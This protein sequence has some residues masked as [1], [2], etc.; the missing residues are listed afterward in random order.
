MNWEFE[1]YPSVRRGRSL[2][3]EA[4]LTEFS[5]RNVLYGL[6]RIAE[7][8]G[9]DDSQ[10]TSQQV[11][12]FLGKTLPRQAHY[13]PLPRVDYPAQSLPF[14]RDWLSLFEPHGLG[15]KMWEAVGIDATEALKVLRLSPTVSPA[16]WTND[17]PFLA[18]LLFN[19]K[20]PVHDLAHKLAVSR[21]IYDWLE[22][23][24]WW[25]TSTASPVR[26]APEPVLKELIAMLGRLSSVAQIYWSFGLTPP[27]YE[28]SLV[29]TWA[30]Y[31]GHWQGTPGASV[32]SGSA[33]PIVY[34][35]HQFL[36]GLR[37]SRCQLDFA[38]ANRHVAE[39][40]EQVPE[41]MEHFLAPWPSDA[42]LVV[43]Q[44]LS[45]LCSSL[46][47]KPSP[48]HLAWAALR[49][50]DELLRRALVGVD[51]D[52]LLADLER[53]IFG[54]LPDAPLALDGVQLGAAA[55]E[56]GPLYQLNGANWRTQN[57]T[58]ITLDSQGLVVNIR[59]EVLTC[60]GVPMM[61]MQTHPF[62]AERLL[63]QGRLEQS[64]PVFGGWLTVK[65]HQGGIESIELSD[66]PGTP[67]S[68]RRWPCF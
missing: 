32:A 34:P 11:L 20:H 48:L 9:L 25:S 24:G 31:D 58:A 13:D 52:R 41:K 36:A 23:Q 67:V 15:W 27:R 26:P 68:S 14:T 10:L 50:P 40:L 54:T 64:A 35:I 42:A 51:Q 12:E 56:L 49:T 4:G 59:G 1:D 28:G 19:H 55:A 8:D 46:N 17:A 53:E 3:H 21:K 57:G 60:R 43:M 37:E 30:I 33:H 47:L 62:D 65:T 45:K 44:E 22:R 2:A 16:A 5:A 66:S 61:D 38:Y 7:E 29:V 18:Q 39:F 6:L 63:G